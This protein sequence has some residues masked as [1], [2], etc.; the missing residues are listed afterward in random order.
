MS[1]PE[2]RY[3]E[4]RAAPDGR[5]L[6]GVAVRYGDTARLPWGR[7]RV[8][9]GAFA[10]TGDVILNASHERAA[11]LARVG[12]GLTLDDTAERLAFSAEL[13]AT[14]GGR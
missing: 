14:R 11:P 2:R 5:R 7:E 9:A 4:L 6:E 1:A 13:P 8:E 3:V 10:P 12:A